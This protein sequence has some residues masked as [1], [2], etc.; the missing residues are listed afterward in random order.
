[1]I[2]TSEA[3]YPATATVP[4]DPVSWE[5][6]RRY[7]RWI[8]G[9]YP[10]AIVGVSELLSDMMMEDNNTKP[11]SVRPLLA[12]GQMTDLTNAKRP[13]PKPVLAVATGQSG[14]NLRLVALDYA[15]WHCDGDESPTIRLLH[16][17][18]DDMEDVVTW[19]QDD[20]P[21][22]QVKTGPDLAR[23]EPSR[24]VILQ[25][26]LS[27]TVLCPQ[28]RKV[29]V[30]GA[31]SGVIG[32]LDR[33]SRIDPKPVLYLSYQNTGGSPHS[34]VA[35][36]PRS[37]ASPEMLAIVDERGY[38][39]VWGMQ[40][41]ITKVG[42]PGLT[43]EPRFC[44]QIHAGVLENLPNEPDSSVPPEYH[45]V[46]W[47][48]SSGPDSNHPD[49]PLFYPQGPH[50]EETEGDGFVWSLE[51]PMLLVW[52]RFSL[53]WI[54][55]RNPN[56]H[57]EHGPQVLKTRQDV[58]QDVQSNPAN[59]KQVF[60]L[61][62]SDLFWMELVPMQDAGSNLRKPT[63]ILSCA[64]L[65][66]TGTS[67]G[68][69]RIRAHHARP[70][71]GF[72]ASVV[73][74]H[75]DSSPDVDIFTFSTSRE[76]GYPQFQ[77]HTLTVPQPGRDAATSI[78]PALQTLSLAPALIDPNDLQ[79][80]SPGEKHSDRLDHLW[81]LLYL[82]E[83]LSLRC[84]MVVASTSDA[85]GVA[86][87]NVTRKVPDDRLIKRLRGK[88]R[89]DF[90]QHHA[91][92]FVMSDA[93]G[94]VDDV[95]WTA[96]LSTHGSALRGGDANGLRRWPRGHVEGVELL[97]SRVSVSIDSLALESEHNRASG[98]VPGL[99]SVKDML[100]GYLSVNEGRWPLRT[101]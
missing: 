1:M 34:D 33:P 6:E 52:N 37:G 15:K 97:M 74:L 82:H 72:D 56:H 30:P 21:I 59:Q 44:G 54:D 24:Y 29:P 42:R 93:F 49:A 9:T 85:K 41:K 5:E 73:C 53:Q 10:E 70:S 55:L 98:N 57:Q 62:S 39:S 95:L 78:I 4:P 67:D 88:R 22:F 65:R 31:S 2:G 58:I 81:Q 77:Y 86:I 89:M 13:L 32:S 14:E 91:K 35:F 64:H 99:E 18:Q 84:C 61:T 76:T 17:M 19:A 27:T 36:R 45:G 47:V 100:Q 79:W 40:G 43:S 90:L 26:Q 3:W 101:L 51:A 75:S 94:D 46:L 48:G 16:P 80:A 50:D 63:I 28:Y 96:G 38:W 8:H 66:G 69:I 71:L 68:H 92:T 25:K 7:R 11:F 23:P 87:P 83:D 60:V 12:I 20:S